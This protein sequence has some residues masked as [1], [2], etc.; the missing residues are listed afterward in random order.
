MRAVDGV[1][2]WGERYDL[3]RQDLLTLQDS[4]ASQ[5]ASALEVRMTAAEQERVYSRYTENIGAFEAYMQGRLELA[6]GTKEGAL[7]A[8]LAFENAVRQDSTYAL[9]RAG[10]AMA[11]SS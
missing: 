11:S 8:I 6:R 7:A 1:P 2:L 3:A 5:V 10:L 4:I 9:A